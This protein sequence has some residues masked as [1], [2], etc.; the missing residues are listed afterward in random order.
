MHCYINAGTFTVLTWRMK[1]ASARGCKKVKIQT[2][3]NQRGYYNILWCA[4]QKWLFDDIME[5]MSCLLGHQPSKYYL[6]STAFQRKTI[7]DLD[8]GWDWQEPTGGCRD[9]EEDPG[10]LFC[11]KWSLLKQILLFQ[12]IFWTFMFANRENFILAPLACQKLW[13]EPACLVLRLQLHTTFEL[14]V[15]GS[16]NTLMKHPLKTTCLELNGRSALSTYTHIS[17][18]LEVNILASL[19]PSASNAAPKPKSPPFMASTRE[20]A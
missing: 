12:V 4:L 14:Y 18:I 5:K 15:P 17:V 2:P 19:T 3:E 10:G 6:V 8:G 9:D 7:H 16:L 1:A 13:L 20:L 11:I